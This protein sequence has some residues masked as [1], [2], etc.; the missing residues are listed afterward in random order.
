MGIRLLAPTSFITNIEIS[1]KQTLLVIHKFINENLKSFEVKAEAVDRWDQLMDEQ[2]QSTIFGSEFEGHSYYKMFRA[3]PKPGQKPYKC[4]TFYPG[5]AE[6]MSSIF[7]KLVD[8]DWNF[9][10]YEGEQKWC[11][12]D[13]RAISKEL[14]ECA[15]KV[16]FGGVYTGVGCDADVL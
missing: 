16:K 9:E 3:K 14:K 6:E 13:A 2:S 15:A 10:A 1:M 4:P 7:S 11:F 8:E 12:G 5:T